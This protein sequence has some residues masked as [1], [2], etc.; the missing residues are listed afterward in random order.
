VSLQS[1]EAPGTAPAASS[2]FLHFTDL[3]APGRSQRAR[4]HF[5]LAGLS[6]AADQRRAM[7]GRRRGRGRGR[8]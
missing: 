1:R 4:R 8:D 3:N 6:R 5:V 7:R 2:L